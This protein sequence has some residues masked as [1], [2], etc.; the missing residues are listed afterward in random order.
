[1]RGAARNTPGS[2]RCAADAAAVR[3]AN[4]K[5][6]GQMA[7]FPGSGIDPGLAL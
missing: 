2:W 1:M 5:K 7:A 3:H 6:G 4:D